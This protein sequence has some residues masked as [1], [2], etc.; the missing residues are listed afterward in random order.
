MQLYCPHCKG[1]CDQVVP[2]GKP[3]EYEPGT[4]IFFV[5]CVYCA[6][7]LVLEEDT[8][9]RPTALEWDAVISNAEIFR[10][11]KNLQ[12]TVELFIHNSHSNRPLN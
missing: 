3:D 10:E 6:Y 2:F 4:F 9:R 8:L 12:H 7:I 5:I 1:K 11:L